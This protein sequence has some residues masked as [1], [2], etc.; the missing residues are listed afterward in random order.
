MNKKSNLAVRARPAAKG[1]LGLPGEI[2]NQIYD[3][4]FHQGFKCEFAEKDAKLGRKQRDSLK[5]FMRKLNPCDVQSLCE[6]RFAPTA[7]VRFSRTLGMYIEITD[8]QRVKVILP[9]DTRSRGGHWYS[10]LLVLS[11]TYRLAYR[12]L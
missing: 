11:H 1:F 4:Y 3:Y 6:K 9:Q 5:F 12:T 10:I 8:L 2:R 7:T